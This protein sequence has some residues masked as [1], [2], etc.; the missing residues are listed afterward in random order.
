MIAYTLEIAVNGDHVI[1]FIVGVGLMFIA[2]LALAVMS[3]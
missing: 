2:T 3:Q 1:G